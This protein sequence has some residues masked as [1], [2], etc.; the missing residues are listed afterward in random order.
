M[1]FLK[2]IAQKEEKLRRTIRKSIKAK[3]WD[4]PLAL[5]KKRTA[6]NDSINN[7]KIRKEERSTNIRAIIRNLKEK[8]SYLIC[9][10]WLKFFSINLHQYWAF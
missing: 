7:K 6:N 1:H 9:S 5:E 8:I 10:K 2:K 4:I 3:G